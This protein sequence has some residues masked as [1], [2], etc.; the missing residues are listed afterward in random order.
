[1]KPLY[2]PV[3]Y[4]PYPYSAGQKPFKLRPELAAEIKDMEAGPFFYT[5][6]EAI[7]WAQSN[8]ERLNALHESKN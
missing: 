2:M 4:G 1:M 7:E 8:A 5:E 6:R 3:I